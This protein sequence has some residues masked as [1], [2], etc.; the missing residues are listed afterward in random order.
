MLS[1]VNRI[2][3]QVSEVFLKWNQFVDYHFVEKSHYEINDIDLD[4][5]IY[6]IHCEG[7][8]YEFEYNET[9]IQVFHKH[10]GLNVYYM[11][12]KFYVKN[13]VFVLKFRHNDLDYFKKRRIKRFIFKLVERF[14]IKS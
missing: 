3:Y 13:K 7:R 1:V 6:R 8:A 9:E 14:S 5:E 11:E 12:V 2:N 10:E 4:N